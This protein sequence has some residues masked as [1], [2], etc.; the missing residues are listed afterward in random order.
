MKTNALAIDTM[1]RLDGHRSS[2]K[3]AVDSC[4]EHMRKVYP[5]NEVVRSEE[6]RHGQTF[7]FVSVLSQDGRELL[8]THAFRTFGKYDIREGTRSFKP[9]KVKS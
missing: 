9:K 5:K 6:V 4:V 7:C 2:L 1:C 8:E 3:K